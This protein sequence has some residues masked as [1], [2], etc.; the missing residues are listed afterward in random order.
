MEFRYKFDN[1]KRIG[2]MVSTMSVVMEM[3]TSLKE[4]AIVN[5]FP[6]EYNAMVAS[7]SCREMYQLY[8]AKDSLLV[9][10][11]RSYLLPDEIVD[12]LVN[13]K[14]FD[15][16]KRIEFIEAGLEKELYYIDWLRQLIEKIYYPILCGK[17]FSDEKQFEST[18]SAME[19]L[20]EFADEREKVILEVETIIETHREEKSYSISHEGHNV[21]NN[22]DDRLYEFIPQ[23]K[24][25]DLY[26]YMSATG[27]FKTQVGLVDFVM[28]INTANFDKIIG[29]V[30]KSYLMLGLK[31]LAPFSVCE[32]GEWLKQCASSLNVAIYS[33]GKNRT[34][35]GKWA[36]DLAQILS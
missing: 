9:D 33:M 2:T 16:K 14:Y 1:T 3:A 7:Y 21:R 31:M 29:K 35:L 8:V 28:A 26:D 20:K 22:V 10:I 32:N 4:A 23:S 25:T 34:A 11:I 19:V 18:K 15:K 17:A 13:N 27:V 30:K 6:H 36:D 24:V 5:I 12:I